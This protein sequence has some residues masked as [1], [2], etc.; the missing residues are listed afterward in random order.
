MGSERTVGVGGFWKVRSLYVKFMGGSTSVGG[1]YKHY[2]CR[3]ASLQIVLK[4][5][6]ILS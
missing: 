2:I 4:T 1:Q 3:A 5:P 6:K